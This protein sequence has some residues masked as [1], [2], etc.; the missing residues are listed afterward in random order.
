MPRLL[1]I[2]KHRLKSQ[3]TY[4]KNGRTMLLK[5]SRHYPE[6]ADERRKAYTFAVEFLSVDGE[7]DIERVKE[8]CT[9]HRYTNQKNQLNWIKQIFDTLTLEE[10][11]E[12][13]WHP[14]DN[15]IDL[16]RFVH[17]MN[18]DNITWFRMQR[19]DREFSTE[20]AKSFVPRPKL[21]DAA[22][23][24]LNKPQTQ[25]L[26]YDLNNLDGTPGGDEVLKARRI[27][28]LICLNLLNGPCRRLEYFN[29]QCRK[30]KD[31][32]KQNYFIDSDH[33]FGANAP[34]IVLEDY[35]TSNDY[36]VF[37]KYPI[38]YMTLYLLRTIPKSRTWLEEQSVQGEDGF[39]QPYHY[40][41]SR[42]KTRQMMTAFATIL[43]GRFPTPLPRISC[44]LLRKIDV[45]YY[46]DIGVLRLPEGRRWLADQ[47]GNNPRTQLLYY[48][49]NDP[50]AFQDFDSDDIPATQAD[51]NPE[52]EEE[53]VDSIVETTGSDDHET[54]PGKRVR[55]TNTVEIIESDEDVPLLPF[56]A[57]RKDKAIEA[58]K[59]L[60]PTWRGVHNKWPK[61]FALQEMFGGE[62]IGPLIRSLVPE[63][64][65]AP[66]PYKK[67]Q[68][69]IDRYESWN[70]EKAKIRNEKLQQARDTAFHNKR[71]TKNLNNQPDI[72]D[73]TELMK[74]D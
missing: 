14:F 16:K 18:D 29:L 74:S 34:R 30:S 73:E 10:A 49:K 71:L 4:V 5:K 42:H 2:I 28:L 50:T 47:H 63:P 31:G 43:K 9:A 51:E 52:S 27:A 59:S 57:S 39:D 33:N 12:Y 22:T 17:Q 60:G 66:N 11:Q 6:W 44:D 45:R 70:G 58:L 35:K 68:E 25:T 21:V 46:L 67:F 61:I 40:F 23:I 55:Q 1:D 26:L 38:D 48:F 64:L 56:Y 19:E 8:Y 53:L 15:F 24:W 65:S 62:A 3:N 7:I 32:I 69:R 13:D 41:D 37:V 36:G 72:E 54:P 20:E